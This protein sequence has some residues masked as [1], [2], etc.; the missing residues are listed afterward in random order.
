MNEA[1]RG[2]EFLIPERQFYA[3]SN[4]IL[5]SQEHLYRVQRRE[6]TGHFT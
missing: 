1:L 4:G 5:I 6:V 3:M 2:F